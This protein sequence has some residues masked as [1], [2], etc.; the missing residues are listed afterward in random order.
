MLLTTK[1]QEKKVGIITI[2]FPYFLHQSTKE[3][4]KLENRE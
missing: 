2:F 3:K 4:G 1:N